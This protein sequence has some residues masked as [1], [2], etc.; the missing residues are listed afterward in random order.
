MKQMLNAFGPWVPVDDM[1]AKTL[2]QCRHP[3]PIVDMG[4]TSILQANF[5]LIEEQTLP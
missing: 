5:T 3:D 4:S 1:A 2:G